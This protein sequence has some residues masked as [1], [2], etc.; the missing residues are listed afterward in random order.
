MNQTII[1]TFSIGSTLAGS[2]IC[3]RL[4]VGA[5]KLFVKDVLPS[6]KKSETSQQHQCKYHDSI[7]DVIEEFKK[8]S[9]ILI[10]IEVR[11]EERAKDHIE[12]SKNIIELFDRLRN[13]EKNIAVLENSKIK[14]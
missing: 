12:M 7:S 3:I 6:F 5:A 10:R 14:L 13:A 1:D 8:S 11:L 9:E 2:G 4:I